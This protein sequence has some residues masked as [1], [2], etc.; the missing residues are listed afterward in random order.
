MEGPVRKD[1]P[2]LPPARC[3]LAWLASLEQWGRGL[4]SVLPR[5][6]RG[7]P[8]WYHCVVAYL[9]ILCEI[10]PNEFLFLLSRLVARGVVWGCLWNC[11][12]VTFIDPQGTSAIGITVHLGA[13]KWTCVSGKFC[14]YYCQPNRSKW[15]TRTSISNL[16]CFRR[17]NWMSYDRTYW[18]ILTIR[19]KWLRSLTSST[20]HK[21]LTSF[22]FSNW[23][24]YG[25]LSSLK[26]CWLIGIKFL[27]NEGNRHWARQWCS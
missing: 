25:K 2:S 14:R 3:G 5:N 17:L 1:N 8:S 26:S 4:W 12:K 27:V 7:R 10:S 15:Q 13:Q 11:H 22:R 18:S 6:V 9:V 16:L 19:L 24:L 20:L 21:Q 23:S